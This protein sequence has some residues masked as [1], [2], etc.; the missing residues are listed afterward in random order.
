MKVCP[1]VGKGG[2]GKSSVSVILCRNAILKGFNAAVLQ[3]DSQRNAADIA[4]LAGVNI[5]VLD[6]DVARAKK[7]IDEMTEGTFLDKYRDYMELFREDLDY[8]YALRLYLSEHEKTWDWM[9]IDMPPNCLT[10]RFLGLQFA[11]DNFIV[12]MI[13]GKNRIESLFGSRTSD[14][15]A[16]ISSL[17][18]KILFDKISTVVVTTPDIVSICEADKISEICRKPTKISSVGFNPRL[19]VINRIPVENAYGEIDLHREYVKCDVCKSR[20]DDAMSAI[21]QCNKKMFLR[22]LPMDTI[23]ESIGY[24]Y[25]KKNAGLCLPG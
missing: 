12:R 16:E 21:V 23:Y 8:T 9:F 18:N 7:E 19:L 25:I 5:P 1:V 15:I 2:V 10:M 13:T 11:A 17:G 20:R 22:D 6:P 24:E 4:K 14:R 3:L